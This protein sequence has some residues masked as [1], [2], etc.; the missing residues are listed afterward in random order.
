MTFRVP[1]IEKVKNKAQSFARWM[2]ENAFFGFLILFFIA[3]LI[4]SAVFYQ[5]VFSARGS[6]VQSEIKQ[7][8]FQQEALEHVMQ[9]WQE[10]AQNFEQAGQ[11][12]ERNIF[13]PLLSTPS[14]PENAEQ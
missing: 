12:L 4:S 10:R 3:L 7:T 6:K 5:Y 1:D 8:N 13:V 2:G 9:T 14:A 11:T